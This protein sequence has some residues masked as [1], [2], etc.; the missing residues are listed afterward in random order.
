MKILKF[1]VLFF[2]FNILA[3]INKDKTYE[4][5]GDAK[6]CQFGNNVIPKY[7]PDPSPLDENC[8]TCTCQKPPVLHCQLAEKC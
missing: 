2:F 5:S 6:S 1:F 7:S 4:L 8:T 3:E